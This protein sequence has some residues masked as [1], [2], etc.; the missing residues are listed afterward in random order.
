MAGRHRPGSLE[1]IA[2]NVDEILATI[3]RLY[4]H[5]GEVEGAG[6]IEFLDRMSWLPPLLA[7]LDQGQL[8]DG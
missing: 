4:A 5:A 3:E 2:A 1:W 7:E 6:V 8:L